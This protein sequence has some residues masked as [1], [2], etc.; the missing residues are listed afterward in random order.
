MQR[1]KITKVKQKSK[2][3]KCNA[4]AAMWSKDT[5]FRGQGRDQRLEKFPRQKTEFSRTSALKEK[6]K[7]ERSRRQILQLLAGV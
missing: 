2:C 6:L 4:P 1:H 3:N 5:I 7:P